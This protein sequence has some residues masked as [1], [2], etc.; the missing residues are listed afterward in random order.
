MPR[1]TY[2]FDWTD[3][4]GVRGPELAA[5]WARLSV[6]ADGKCITRVLDERAQTI[7]DYI[8]VPLYPLAEWLAANWW[9]LT[10]ECANPDKENAPD[11]YRRHALG[12][13]REGY[14]YPNLKIVPHDAR[15]QISWDISPSQWRKTSFLEAGS[16][17]LDSAEFR[18]IGSALIDQVI[19][20]LEACGID[21]TLLQDEWAAI[22]AAD[23]DET[24]FCR[25]AAGLGWDPYDLDENR[26]QTIF[27]L[28][29][30]LG[31]LLDEAIPALN[32]D[33]PVA[34]CRIIVDAIAATKPANGIPLAALH[35]VREAIRAGNGNGSNPWATGYDWAR[36][37]RQRLQLN[38]EPLPDLAQI[39][40]ALGEPAALVDQVMAPMLAGV[41]MSAAMVA[42]M[43]DGVITQDDSGAP[44]F[45][46]RRIHEQGRTFL[47]CRALAEVL[48][49]PAEN[50]LLTRAY[51]ARQQRN[52]AFAAEFLAPSAQLQQMM[53]RS[54]LDSDDIDELAAHFGVSAQ[55]IG[56][57]I[58]NHRIGRILR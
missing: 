28:G 41:G 17:W 37:L 45:G 30:S 51:S 33:N 42:A 8:Y 38:G 3:A 12:P 13:Q 16:I 53:P 7:R 9:F 6:R 19:R 54:V 32:G 34:D 22:Q 57:Q 4:P 23:A 1:L 11:F 36:R 15:T 39:A 58:E 25:T 40:D 5:T 2:D 49:S 10:S 44:A 29:E 47:F 21:D 24:Q 18:T 26:Q 55:V 52:R 43:I 14:A 31:S 35:P 48:A 27:Q 56:H 50:A 46:M 20:R